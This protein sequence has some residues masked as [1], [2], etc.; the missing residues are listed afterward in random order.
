MRVLHE[1]AKGLLDHLP[2]DPALSEGEERARP[3][4][5]LCDPRPFYEVLLRS[6]ALDER[7]D[8]PG[9][10]VFEPGHLPPEDCDLLLEA[11]EAQVRV[12]TTAL[13]R[14]AELSRAVRR[15]HDKRYRFRFDRVELVG[16]DLMITAYP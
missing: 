9:E 3:V 1:E 5:R 6:D 8:V 12:Q 13:Q 4:Q 11:R 10:S 2:R 16:G 7:R 15:D 14:V